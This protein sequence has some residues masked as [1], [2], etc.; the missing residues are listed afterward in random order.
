MVF[1]LLNQFKIN[2]VDLQ[3]LLRKTEGLGP[4]TSWQPKYTDIKVPHPVP[5]LGEDKCSINLVV[6]IQ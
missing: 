3:C 6:L 1:Y 5:Q 2:Y 4:W